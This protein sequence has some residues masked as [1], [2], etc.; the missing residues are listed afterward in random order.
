MKAKSPIA[1]QAEIRSWEN[2]LKFWQ[3]KLAIEKEKHLGGDFWAIER[4]EDIE[5]SIELC[6]EEILKLRSQSIVPPELDKNLAEPDNDLAIDWLNYV[7]KIFPNQ[8]HPLSK[9]QAGIWDLRAKY[10]SSQ[11]TALFRF[12]KS[13]HDPLVS[14]RFIFPWQWNQTW[15]FGSSWRFIDQAFSSMSAKKK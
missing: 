8:V 5:N 3:E 11:I 14:E 6:Q 4:I 12:I 13:S 7:L 2:H 15:K 1:L 9:Y 10:S